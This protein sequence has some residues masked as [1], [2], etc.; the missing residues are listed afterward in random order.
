MKSA[1]FPIN[2]QRS[3]IDKPIY[4]AILQLNEKI[5]SLKEY[6]MTLGTFGPTLAE[7]MRSKIL[8]VP[9]LK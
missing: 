2:K 8:L 3:F 1:F 6:L 4:C 9:N 5:A 7:Q